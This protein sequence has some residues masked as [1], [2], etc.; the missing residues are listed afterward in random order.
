MPDIRI[1]QWDDL[2]RHGWDSLLLGNG[3]SISIHGG[4]H[5]DSLFDVASN[6]GLLRTTLPIFNRLG[7]TDFEHVLSSC[8]YAEQVNLALGAP[9]GEITQAYAEVRRAL[10]ESVHAVHPIHA[11]VSDALFSAANFACRFRTVVTLNYDVTLYWATLLFNAR[12]GNW[13]KDAFVLAGG[14]FELEWGYLRQPHGG[15]QEATLVFYPHGS[16]PISRTALGSEFK[17]S[18]N[19]TGERNLLQTISNFWNPGGVSPVFVSEG[20]SI[21]K[22][23]AIRR[24]SYL[25]HVYDCVLP[26]L[27]PGLVTYGW[28]FDERDAHIL[29]AIGNQRA[30]HPLQRLAVSVY[31]GES[32]ARQ[33]AFCH[34]V[35]A[36]AQ[37]WL[38]GTHVAFFDSRSPNCW[39]NM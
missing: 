30:G 18:A 6:L 21:D 35:L 1:S 9:S 3:A 13:F 36:L 28:G 20:R 37:Q 38:P 27:G 14:T 34:R 29:A 16:L 39:S 2:V 8:W 23:A 4:F 24:S 31:T 26:A 32:A 22:L 10:I 19:E 11:D 25:S 5:Y 17:L 33:Q 12:Y 7:A 15:A